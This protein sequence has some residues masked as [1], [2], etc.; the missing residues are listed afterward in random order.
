MMCIRSEHAI[1]FLKGHFHSL[2]NLCVSISD[3]KSHILTTYW[4]AACIGIHSFAMQCKEEERQLDASE[5]ASDLFASEDPF[6]A[7]G[8]SSSSDSEVNTMTVTTSIPPRAGP[9]THLQAGKAHRE[10]LKEQL[11][12]AKMH[13]ARRMA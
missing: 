1:G 3:K 12:C 13:K 7:E 11:F 8:L 4:V 5:S 9:T 6:V 2:K 10:K